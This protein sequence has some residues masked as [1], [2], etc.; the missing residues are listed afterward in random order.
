[1]P[2]TELT[3]FVGNVLIMVIVAAAFRMLL[4]AGLPW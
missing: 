2:L 3:D 1:M 4:R